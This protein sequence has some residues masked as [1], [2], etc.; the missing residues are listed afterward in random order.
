MSRTSLL[1][2]SSHS[3]I[4]SLLPVPVSWSHL[5]PGV[6]P[7]AFGV[8]RGLAVWP[9]T[10]T[11]SLPSRE[12]MPKNP[13]FSLVSHFVIAS[14]AVSLWWWGFSRAVCHESNGHEFQV[15]TVGIEIRDDDSEETTGSGIPESR[16]QKKWD[17][18]VTIY[19]PD[20]SL[21]FDFIFVEI[22]L[23]CL[24]F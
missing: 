20:C 1:T 8:C 6:N 4:Q 11:T 2:P 9:T 14:R 7:F 10:T 12:E 22:F 15:W 3:N 18:Y 16:W 21:N 23:I 13:D 17:L 19:R 24:S 5:A